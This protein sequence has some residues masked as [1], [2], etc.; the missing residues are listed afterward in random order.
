M[1][2]NTVL[3]LK[4]SADEFSGKARCDSRSDKRQDKTVGSLGVRR[5]ARLRQVET[6]RPVP[7]LITWI[8]IASFSHVAVTAIH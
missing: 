6:E 8:F 5:A 7:T 4:G 2:E 1:E 3:I